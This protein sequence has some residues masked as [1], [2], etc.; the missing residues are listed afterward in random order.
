MHIPT[1]E[2]S[3]LFCNLD[4]KRQPLNPITN[5][6][7]RNSE[8]LPCDDVFWKGEREFSNKFCNDDLD[9]RKSVR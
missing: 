9:F 8:T 1:G 6:N 3:P 2:I 4:S 5:R 7:D